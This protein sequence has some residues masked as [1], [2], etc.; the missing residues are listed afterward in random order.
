[1]CDPGGGTRAHRRAINLSMSVSP[2]ASG[3]E[4]TPAHGGF[5]AAGV[6]YPTLMCR[7]NGVTLAESLF[8]SKYK[9][10]Q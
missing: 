10:K 5:Q 2:Y 4:L 9:E 3:D 6:E 8:S 1:M 7:H